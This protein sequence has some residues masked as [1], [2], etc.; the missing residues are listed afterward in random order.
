MYYIEIWWPFMYHSMWHILTENEIKYIVM[1][2]NAASTNTDALWLIFRMLS[3]ISNLN[4]KLSWNT[5]QEMC[6]DQQL[7][8]LL[9]W[10]SSVD[11][12]YGCVDVWNCNNINIIWCRIF[13]FCIV[14]ARKLK[15]V[16]K[17][18]PNAE[19]LSKLYSFNFSYNFDRPLYSCVMALCVENMLY[20]SAIIL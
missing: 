17:F 18:C 6:K 9:N 2:G 4:D 10:V 8:Y 19:N 5:V 16:Y 1:R 11:L 20:Q 3:G 7:W 14:M 13:K 12:T 15:I